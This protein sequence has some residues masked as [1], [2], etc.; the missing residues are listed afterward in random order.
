MFDCKSCGLPMQDEEEYKWRKN[1]CRKCAAADR[2]RLRDENPEKYRE[3]SRR[4]SVKYAQTYAK[5]SKCYSQALSRLR[6][7]HR[8]EFE[9]Y[10]KAEVE[11]TFKSEEPKP[12]V[13]V[14][15]VEQHPAP[16]PQPQTWGWGKDAEE[17]SRVHYAIETYGGP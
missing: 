12:E 9:E 14:E 11:K 1:W 13:Q 2:K 7:N 4:S 6:D 15:L 5:R 17:E 16:P 3:I 8:E 10:Y